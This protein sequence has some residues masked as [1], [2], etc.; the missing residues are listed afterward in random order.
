MSSPR[1]SWLAILILV[2][3]ILKLG[4][5]WSKWNPIVLIAFIHPVVSICLLRELEIA[6]KLLISFSLFI[7]TAML[8]L[9]CTFGLLMLTFMA[10]PDG[11]NA[12]FFIWV[13]ALFFT[14]GGNFSLF[15]T[16]TARWEND[17]PKCLWTGMKVF[18][19]NGIWLTCARATFKNYAILI[20]QKLPIWKVRF[21]APHSNNVC[22]TP[23]KLTGIQ[24]YYLRTHDPWSLGLKGSQLGA[25]SP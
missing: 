25:F 15:P 7:Q 22:Y 6:P 9:C 17:T 21:F 24:R 19:S 11:G 8:T 2:M 1:C 10:T 18:C 20:H 14:F 5:S 4:A 12:M 16:A 3:L 13:C 23:L